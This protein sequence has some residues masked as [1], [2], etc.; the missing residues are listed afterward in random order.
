MSAHFCNR[1]E[2]ALLCLIL[3]LLFAGCAA[4]SS[5]MLP[6][7]GQLARTTGADGKALAE[8][9]SYYLRECAGCHRH[10]WPTENTPSEW[11]QT[12]KEHRGR[13]VLTKEQLGKVELYLTLASQAAEKKGNQ[14]PDD[15]AGR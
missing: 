15:K 1:T 13:V 7:P 3:S 2:K 5:R 4:T 11:K 9:R 12:L 10:F 6:D 8:G 14:S